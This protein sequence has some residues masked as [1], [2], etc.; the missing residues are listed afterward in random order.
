MLTI[1]FGAERSHLCY[2]VVRE[3]G[4]EK[5][6]KNPNFSLL[7]KEFHQ[8]EFIELRMKVHLL[9]EGYAWVPK[10]RDFAWD[11]REESGKSKF[12]SVGNVHET[13]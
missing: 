7:S 6:G 8:S 13:S 12:S 10:T 2:L 3:E 5:K 4:R 11:P 1:I 9:N